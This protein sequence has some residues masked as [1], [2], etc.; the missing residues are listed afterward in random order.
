MQG[1]EYW[2][3]TRLSV[4][5]WAT[6]GRGVLC[7]NSICR[8]FPIALCFSKSHFSL[9]YFLSVDSLRSIPWAANQWPSC[10]LIVNGGLV[11][12]CLKLLW[13]SGTKHWSSFWEDPWRSSLGDEDK[14]RIW[15]YSE[16]L[17]EAPK[18][19][20]QNQLFI[21]REPHW[22]ESLLAYFY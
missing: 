3:Y 16:Q 22:V 4:V 9:S 2:L 15:V 1:F 14:K 18:A 7:K 13:V 12:V 6:G 11:E 19:I 5:M 10:T 21:L 17:W 20:D 8:L